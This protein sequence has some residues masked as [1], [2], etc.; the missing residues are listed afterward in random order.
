MRISDWSSDVCSSDLC[1]PADGEAALLLEQ[2]RDGTTAHQRH[3]EQHALVHACPGLGSDHVVV[4]DA[5]RLLA[6]ETEQRGGI[7]L[8]K[9]LGG[10]P[11]FVRAIQDEPYRA[12]AS[13]PKGINWKSFRW[14]KRL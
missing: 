6:H 2:P 3:G 5:H 4:V 1:G 7:G 9:A 10:L 11:R 13:P 8:A 12:H 14:G